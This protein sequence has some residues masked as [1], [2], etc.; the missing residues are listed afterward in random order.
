MAF[1]VF[2]EGKGWRME[3]D[4]VNEVC[5]NLEQLESW[6]GLRRI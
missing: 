1:L 6:N 5:L 3:K 4:A 2:F